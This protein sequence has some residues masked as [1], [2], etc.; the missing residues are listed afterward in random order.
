MLKLPNEV[1]T[2]AS[3]VG[4]HMWNVEEKY[5]RKAF[6]GSQYSGTKSGTTAEAEWVDATDIFSYCYKSTDTR[7][8]LHV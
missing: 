4:T 8:L 7:S 1:D 2:K 6:D 5:R 3:G